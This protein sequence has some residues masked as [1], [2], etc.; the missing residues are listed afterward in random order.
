M[1][2]IRYEWTGEFAKPEIGDWFIS[3]LGFPQKKERRK[4]KEI[5]DELDYWIL[6]RIE[7]EEGE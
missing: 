7:T 5:P 1:S 3:G 6:H 4:G 2:K